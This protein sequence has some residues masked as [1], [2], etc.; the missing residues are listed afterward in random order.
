MHEVRAAVWRRAR[1][2]RLSARV[3]RRAQT[4]AYTPSGREHWSAAP[5][6]NSGDGIRMGEAIGAH[7]DDVTGNA[8]RMGAGFA[9]AGGQGKPE[10]AFPHLIERA[11]PG[12]I[13]VTRGGSASS[14]R[15]RRITTS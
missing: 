3:V 2:R 15:H 9:G 5:R 13:A 1:V 11:K 8:R 7:F 12:V 10:V 14:T 6:A 4:F